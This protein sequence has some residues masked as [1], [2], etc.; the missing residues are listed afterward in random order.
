MSSKKPAQ[1]PGKVLDETILFGLTFEELIVL[2]SFPL[3]IVLPS[4]WIPFIPLLGSIL[5][6][7]V[8]FLLV[9]ITIL[10][11]PPGQTPT[12]WVPDYIKRVIN[13]TV[14]TL[15][16]KD[17]TKEGTP[18]VYYE[19]EVITK[20]QLLEEAEQRREGEG[21][22][23]EALVEEVEGAEKLRTTSAKESQDG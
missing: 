3:V 17:K 21:I 19:D 2:G 6:T 16:P 8:G 15:K 12:E 14:Y 4:I 1:V 23:I 22:D 18:I 7:L 13:P 20:D 10:K 5:I 11:T 9:G